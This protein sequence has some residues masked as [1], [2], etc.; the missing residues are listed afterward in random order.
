MQA[1]GR[2]FGKD[3][4]E[5]LLEIFSSRFSAQ[6]LFTSK[7]IPQACKGAETK[8]T[9]FQHYPSLPH[10][11]VRKYLTSSLSC[12][13]LQSCPLVP[14]SLLPALT[15]CPTFSE[16]RPHLSCIFR[17]WLQCH[18]TRQVDSHLEMRK[19][20][21]NRRNRDSFPLFSCFSFLS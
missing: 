14:L 10:G 6:K 17:I 1:G 5:Y 2:D 21:A 15:I 4:G 11:H 13:F 20:S 19:R 3:Q 12:L 7:S 9:H 18:R 8:R 16:P